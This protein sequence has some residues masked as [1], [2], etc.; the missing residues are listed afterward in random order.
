MGVAGGGD[1]DDYEVRRTL[2]DSRVPVEFTL[3]SS[4]LEQQLRFP[5]Q[6]AY[7]SV[8]WFAT[9]WEHTQTNF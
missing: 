8:L 6:S 1:E 4:D 7:V 2:W 9:F 3:D 5:H